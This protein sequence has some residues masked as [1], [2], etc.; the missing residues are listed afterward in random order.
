MKKTR[1]EVLFATPE[2]G[3]RRAP[4][5]LVTRTQYGVRVL[6]I[7]ED[8]DHGLYLTDEEFTGLVTALVP[9]QDVTHCRMCGHI[10]IG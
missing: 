6:V 9:K 4:S 3:S 7:D 1:V 2:D 8:G 10:Q 5:L